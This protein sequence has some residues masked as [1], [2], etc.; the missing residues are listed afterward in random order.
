MIGL[1][2]EAETKCSSCG[3]PL[4]INALVE[5]IV[6]NECLK[7]NTFT[8]KEWKDLLEDMFK[9]A[10]TYSE[11]EGTP[12]TIMG[13]RNYEIT[14]GKQN[15]R[16]LDTKTYMNIE[17]AIKCA[18][19]GKIINPETNAEFSI[20]SIP[21]NFKEACPGVTY[22]FCEDFTQL[23]HYSGTSKVLDQK[24][25]GELVPFNCPNCGGTLQIDGSERLLKCQFCSTESYIPDEVWQKL[26]PTKTKQRFYF[27]FDEKNMK[28][29]WDSALFD[30]VAGADGTLYMSLEP[31]FEANT[32]NELLVVALQPDLTIKWKR[33]NL[34]FKTTTL[35]GEA[36]LGLT[37]N[38]E[39]MVWSKDRNT[40][41]LLSA[42][43]GSEIKRIGKKYEGTDKQNNTVMDFT[44]CWYIAADIDGNYFTYIDRDNKDSDS[45]D[46]YEFMVM[47]KEANL[48]KPWD[49]E[50]PQSKGFFGSLKKAFSGLGEAPYFEKIKDKVYRCRD[51]DVKISI[52]IDGSYYLLSYNYLAKYNLTGK[53]IYL[54]EITGGN[55]CSKISGDK[56]GNAF[57]IF[58]PEGTDKCL[59][60]KVSPDGSTI[61]EFIKNVLDGGVFCEER[62][63]ALSANGTFYSAGYGGCIR[64]FNADG[65]LQYASPKSLEEEKEIKKKSEDMKD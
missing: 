7:K 35:G 13:T 2:L 59:L 10:P 21:E 44:Q 37:I 24:P 11:N 16:F 57:Y 26:H 50:K 55:I 58:G 34:K 56:E 48:H 38:G 54:K 32:N 45:N 36:K 31:S 4:P 33:D 51:Y 30:M 39:L 42:A 8:V 61:S 1:C 12:S 3:K 41:L 46:Y 22:L 27:L 47:D 63:L 17:E 65:K 64:T 20:R 29:E 52:G 6:C 43:D 28:F 60:M 23:P 9:I 62:M 18:P 25:K 53:Q 40:M 19:T 14:Y 15:P 5:T 49:M